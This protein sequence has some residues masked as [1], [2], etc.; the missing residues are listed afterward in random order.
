MTAKTDDPKGR[1]IQLSKAR[2]A[3]D[4]PINNRL[5]DGEGTP[6]TPPGPVTASFALARSFAAKTQ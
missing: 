6:G 1:L 3:T 5:I 4:R 2:S